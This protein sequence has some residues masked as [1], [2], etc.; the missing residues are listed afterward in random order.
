MIYATHLITVIMPAYNRERSVV[1]SIRSVINQHYKNLELL[2]VDDR[3]NDQTEN[4]IR[5][6]ATLDNRI[7]YLKNEFRQGPAGA[8]N[9]GIMH[10]QGSYIAFLD[11]DDLWLPNHLS[12]SLSVLENEQLLFC[13]SKWY[14]KKGDELKPSAFV[15][16][17]DYLMK[18]FPSGKKHSNV[19]VFTPSI[20]EY[21]LLLNFY[22]I[23]ISTVV[24]N[25]AALDAIGCFDETLFGPEDSDMLFRIILKHGMC[26]I[27]DFHSIWVEGDDNIHFFKEDMSNY[28]SKTLPS[29]LRNRLNHVLFFKKQVRFIQKNKHSFSDYRKLKNLKRY[30][31]AYNYRL[32]GRF[33]K[34]RN[35]FMYL[36][37]QCNAYF[38]YH[39]TSK[40]IRKSKENEWSNLLRPRVLFEQLPRME[41]RHI[42][43]AMKNKKSLKLVSTAKK[44]N[45]WMYFEK[46]VHLEQLGDIWVLINR[47]T[48]EGIS[49]DQIPA[50]LGIPV[51]SHILIHRNELNNKDLRK[52]VSALEKN[53]LGGLVD[54]TE[55]SGMPISLYS[56]RQYDSKW[57]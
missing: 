33:F 11:S 42:Y 4:L 27:N 53:N 19:Y 50:I 13:S 35:R 45:F 48:R 21:L 25:K 52:F 14:E 31:V 2:V 30:E 8:R 49:F 1:E 37:M 46:D 56:T 44:T 38:H 5:E 36:K 34:N 20:C 12:E 55:I 15:G 6:Q 57:I 23:H 24:V 32:L 47:K 3:S 18:T 54:S 40:A 39:L 9:F 10:A 28:E 51:K 17:V 22:P 7:K 43:T 26:I 29:I 41:L 16:C